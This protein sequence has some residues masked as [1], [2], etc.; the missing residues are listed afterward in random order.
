MDSTAS[1]SFDGSAIAGPGAILGTVIPD[2]TDY[3]GRIGIEVG[4]QMVAAL[5]ISGGRVELVPASDQQRADAVIVLRDIDDLRQIVRGQLNA[6]V[7]A[8]RA[9]LA[10]RGN[11]ALAVKVIRGLHANAV[12]AAQKRG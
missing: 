12:A 3:S 11:G 1:S 5:Q 2:L 10:V 8:L 9:R 6:V 4:G 7:A